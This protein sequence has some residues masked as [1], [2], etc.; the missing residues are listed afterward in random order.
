M[1]KASGQILRG[2]DVEIAGTFLL[3]VQQTAPT[4]TG[5]ITSAATNVCI[6]ENHPEFAVLEVTCSCG[7]KTHVKSL[8]AAGA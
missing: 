7:A 3:D 6:V 2:S 4:Q 1:K 8:Y 5:N